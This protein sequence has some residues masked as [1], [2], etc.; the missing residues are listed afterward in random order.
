MV[1]EPENAPQPL[2]GRVEEGPEYWGPL[3]SLMFHHVMACRIKHIGNDSCTLFLS[4]SP[5]NILPGAYTN[6]LE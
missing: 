1:F 3:P 5:A 6:A 2:I 4:L